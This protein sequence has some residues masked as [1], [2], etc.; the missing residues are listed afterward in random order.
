MLI[1]RHKQKLFKE[2]INIKNMPELPLYKRIAEDDAKELHK[3]RA[4]ITGVKFGILRNGIEAVL[5]VELT[6]PTRKERFQA[7][8]RASASLLMNTLT[9]YE[10]ED[11]K[12]LEGKTIEVLC[13]ANGTFSGVPITLLAQPAVISQSFKT[14]YGL[15][16]K[17][18]FGNSCYTEF[19]LF[20]ELA[21]KLIKSLG[22]KINPSKHQKVLAW[23]D[24]ERKDAILKVTGA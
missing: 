17:L 13:E 21:D 1:P 23:Y 4:N 11:A 16:L 9:G 18:D 6:F 5:E 10:R 8:S 2:G 14:D 22:G 7:D 15:Y 12:N 3:E 20:G 24:P 19:V